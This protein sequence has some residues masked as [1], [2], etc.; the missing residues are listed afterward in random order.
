MRINKIL[1]AG[2]IGLIIAANISC[3][4]S[5][6]NGYNNTPPPPVTPGPGTVSISGMA[7]KPSTLTVKAGTKITWTN[8]DGFA[9]TVTSDDGSTF[10]SGNVA[11]GGVFTFTPS[12]AGTI[13]YHCNIHSSM[14]ATITV[15]Q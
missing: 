2:T 5:G 15:T 12:A 10:N 14:T 1:L 13:N 9:H 4:K 6:S 8:N 11:A 7:F 3:G